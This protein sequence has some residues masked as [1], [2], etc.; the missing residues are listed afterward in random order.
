[1]LT[2]CGN[3]AAPAQ[4]ADIKQEAD[5]A[6]AVADTSKDEAPAAEGEEVTLKI[7]SN[8]PDRKNG[9]GLVEQ[10][11]IDEYMTLYPNV[12]IEVETLDEEAY[13]TKFKACSMEGMPDVVS[14]WGQ[15]SPG[16]GAGGGRSGRVK[17]GGCGSSS[18]IRTSACSTMC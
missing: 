5:A 4:P 10:M 14:I 17:R 3:S 9:Q 11:I 2:G 12:T 15:L 8:L 18:I 13:K 16:R 7:F 6:T 1:M